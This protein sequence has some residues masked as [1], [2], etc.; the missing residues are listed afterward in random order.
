MPGEVL[1]S[2]AR[3]AICAACPNAVEIPIVGIKC[4]LCGCVMR[5][6]VRQG[7]ARCPDSPPR[8]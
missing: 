4:Q 6:K 3:Y 8:W 2:G 7:N 5:I 1:D